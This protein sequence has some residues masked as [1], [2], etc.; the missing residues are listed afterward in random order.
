MYQGAPDRKDL[1]LAR[2]S[3][4]L[5]TDFG[6]APATSVSSLGS[7]GPGERPASVGRN[8]VTVGYLGA[9]LSLIGLVY[10][11]VLIGAFTSGQTST[12]G[13]VAVPWKALNGDSAG[14]HGATANRP[15]PSRP[16]ARSVRVS[17][18]R[19]GKRHA[20][21]YVMVHS[22]SPNGDDTTSNDPDDDDDNDTSHD[23]TDDDYD[24]DDT[25]QAIT[26][27]VQEI[28]L[29]MIGHD[30]E[31][32]PAWTENLTSPFPARQRLRC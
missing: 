2:D 7:L 17:T 13:S 29:G 31:S 10:F 24:D 1:P 28:V 5:L 26:A 27:S 18:L 30:A 12:A 16:A 14:R 20:I 8:L 21:F 19:S 9:R 15:T 3:G 25:D 32:M 23:H 4:G 11:V 22:D 6:T